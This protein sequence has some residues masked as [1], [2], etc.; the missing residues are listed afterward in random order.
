MTRYPDHCQGVKFVDIDFPDLMAKKCRIVQETPELNSML[1][2]LENGQSPHVL[3][4]SDQYLQIGCDLR[5]L[6]DIREAL[7][8]AMVIPDCEFLFVAEVSI[9]YMET[10]AADAV[11]S[12]AASLSQG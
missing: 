2:S 12:W 11:I 9:T 7:S 5:S 6:G 10:S 1:T 8:S 3:L 4:R